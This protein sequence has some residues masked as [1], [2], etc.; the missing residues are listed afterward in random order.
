MILPTPVQIR[1]VLTTLEKKEFAVL[2]RV[3]LGRR[4][5][6]Q[7]AAPVSVVD[8][9]RLYLYEWLSHWNCFKDSQIERLL[10]R[11]D[12][13]LKHFAEVIEAGATFGNLLVTISDKRY[14]SWS[15]C[16][17][18]YDLEFDDDVKQLDAPAVTFM[19]CNVVA[20][21][22]VKQR[23]LQKLGADDAGHRHP[24]AADSDGAAASPPAPD[25]G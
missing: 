6:E 13:P 10:K 24:Q 4:A 22:T 11:L 3:I 20:L 9:L 23:W 17:C 21:L 12:T 1:G 15:G 19:M 25:R 2:L 8:Q 5:K 18:F 16:K 7:L 14:V